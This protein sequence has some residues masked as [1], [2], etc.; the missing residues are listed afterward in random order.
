[1]KCSDDPRFPIHVG[2]GDACPAFGI[3]RPCQGRQA[4]A[5]R[6]ASLLTGAAAASAGLEKP[7]RYGRTAGGTAVSPS[8]VPP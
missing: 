8:R 4:D 7:S 1:M 6:G 3:F 5:Y 2:N